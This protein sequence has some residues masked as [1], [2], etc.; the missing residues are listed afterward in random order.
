[1]AKEKRRGKGEGSITKETQ[2]IN[3]KQYTRWRGRIR[4]NEIDPRTGKTLYICVSGKTKKEVAKK[5]QEVEIGRLT[6]I[7]NYRGECRLTLDQWFQE[8][9]SSYLVE[10]KASTRELYEQK[11]RL[12]LSPYLGKVKLKDLTPHMIQQLV[13]EFDQPTLR[14]TPD[15]SKKT[16]KDIFSVLRTCLDQAKDNDLILQNPMDK[17]R[18]PKVPKNRKTTRPFNEE[19]LIQFFQEIQGH[20]HE[21]LFLFALYTGMRES[22]ILGLTWDDIDWKNKRIHV[23]KQMAKKKDASGNPVF[24]ETKTRQTRFVVIGPDAIACL[25]EQKLLVNRK[26]AIAGESCW[27]DNDLV[28]PNDTGNKLSHRTVYDCYKRIVKRMG[29]EE[30]R[31][32]DLRHTYATVCIGNGMDIKTVQTN[33][34][35]SDAQTTLNIYSD[36]WQRTQDGCASVVENVYSSLKNAPVPQQ[37]NEK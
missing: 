14:T 27:E 4:S 35:H 9:C 25:R 7:G 11:I 15:L 32:H 17:V 10:I 1:M 12:Y 5:M 22:E 36:V 19:E 24:E 37:K 16:I 21:M 2:T 30:K 28:F 31:F 18:L 29:C 23:E 13:S 34:G 6:G 8:W 3:G 20:K 33:L 26:R